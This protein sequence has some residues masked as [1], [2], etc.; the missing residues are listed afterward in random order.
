MAAQVRIVWYTDPHNVWCWGCEPAIRRFEIRYPESVEIEIRMGGLFEDFSPVREQWARMSGGRWKDSVLAFFEA[1]AAQH[2]MPM[3]AERM[4][5]S[6]DD[7]DSTWPACLAAKAAELQGR[8]RGK[9]YLRRLREAWTIEGQGIHRRSVQEAIASEV[10]LDLGA[11]K[12][13]IEDGSAD[14]AFEKDREECGDLGITGFPTFVLDHAQ[15]SLRLEGWQPWE[16]F[17]DALQKLDPMLR[18]ERIE[19]TKVA[20]G[21][22]LQRYGRCATREVAAVLGATD[23][24]AEIILEELE[25]DA[26]V[27]RRPVGRGLMWELRRKGSQAGAA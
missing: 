15:E 7:F 24:D 12:M 10:G 16:V 25:G 23:D 27:L 21:S 1:V 20:V 4:T 8:E 6:V 17:D 5:D 26:E 11:F 22:L 2:R 13:A 3:D 19:T 9:R 14:R 18:P